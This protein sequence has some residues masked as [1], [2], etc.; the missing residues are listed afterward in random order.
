LRKNL[1]KKSCRTDRGSKDELLC[2]LTL[3]K[4][5]VLLAIFIDKWMHKHK[6][7]KN[8]CLNLRLPVGLCFYSDWQKSEPRRPLHH[9]Q[10]SAGHSIRQSTRFEVSTK[11]DEF[12]FLEKNW[13]SSFLLIKK[14]IKNVSVSSE[15]SE[16][17]HETDRN[18]TSIVKMSWFE[19]KK[20]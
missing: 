2:K 18:S 13:I 20:N 6:D 9:Y 1:R 12:F 15:E 7:I 5:M 11:I 3:S 10:I 17:K 4:W 16:M 19:K 14:S 8:K